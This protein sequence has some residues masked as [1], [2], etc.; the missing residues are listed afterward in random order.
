MG[1]GGIKGVRRREEKGVRRREIKRE[2]TP[3]KNK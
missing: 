3:R 1:G 2:K